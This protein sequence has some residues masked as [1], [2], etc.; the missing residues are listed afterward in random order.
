VNFESV[1]FLYRF[2][3]MPFNDFREGCHV[4]SNEKKNN[5]TILQTVCLE[6][7]INKQTYAKNAVF[8]QKIAK[9]IFSLK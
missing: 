6:L 4:L 5:N 9:H 1:E 2:L 3:F 8:Q 7:N